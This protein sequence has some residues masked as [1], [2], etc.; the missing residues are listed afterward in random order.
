MK[1]CLTEYLTVNLSEPNLE[2]ACL[3]K[4]DLESFKKHLMVFTFG[5]KKVAAM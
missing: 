3:S 4:C 2:K 5:F 1:I